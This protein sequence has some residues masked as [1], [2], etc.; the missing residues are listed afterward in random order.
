MD[1]LGK[2]FGGDMMSGMMNGM[3]DI[4]KN[5][6]DFAKMAKDATAI[7]QQL[8]LQLQAIWQFIGSIIPDVSWVFSVM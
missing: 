3:V 4:I 8:P 7:L 5:I 1:L 6:F 2:L